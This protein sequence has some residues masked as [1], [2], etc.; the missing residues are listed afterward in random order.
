MTLTDEVG[1]LVLNYL[2]RVVHWLDD[3]D[4]DDPRKIGEAI[5]RGLTEAA[6]AEA[7]KR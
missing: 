3:A 1:E 2:T 5:A 7:A 6:E 4:A